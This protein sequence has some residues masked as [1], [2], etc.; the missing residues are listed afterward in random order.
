LTT[1]IVGLT[2][3]SGGLL[4]VAGALLLLPIVGRERS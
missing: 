1:L 2:P 4:L 3:F